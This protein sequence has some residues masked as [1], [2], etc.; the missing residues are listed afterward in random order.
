MSLYFL[1]HGQSDANL[2]GVFSP[3]DAI[4]TD[5]GKR[6]AYEAGERLRSYGI[7]NIVCSGLE[8]SWETAAIVA[9]VLGIPRSEIIRDVRLNEY[10]MG[11]LTGQPSADVNPHEL[12]SA[13]GA[14]NPKAFQARVIDATSAYAGSG[15]TILIVSHAGVGCV[16][17]STRLHHSPDAFNEIPEYANGEIVLIDTNWL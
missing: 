17:E 3:A 1:R 16:L 8:R 10:D 4:L 9:D 14:E 6:Q 7:Q 15:K 2:A 13:E 5:L 12:I 11:S